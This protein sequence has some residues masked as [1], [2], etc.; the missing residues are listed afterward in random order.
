MQQ[1]LSRHEGTGV[2]PGCLGC[3]G[4]GLV[5][6]R[7]A[8]ARRLL[9]IEQDKGLLGRPLLPE[10]LRPVEKLV[11]LQRPHTTQARYPQYRGTQ[12]ALL[13][14]LNCKVVPHALPLPEDFTNLHRF[15]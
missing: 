5:E 12:P 7:V 3:L 1:P 6:G 10:R 4:Q 9:G 8:R 13:E 2:E 15:T 14:G 11:G